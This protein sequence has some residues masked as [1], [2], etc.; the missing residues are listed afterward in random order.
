MTRKPTICGQLQAPAEEE[1]GER[2][3]QD[4]RE[5]PEERPLPHLFR[6]AARDAS[7]EPGRELEDEEDESR[8]RQRAEERPGR[9]RDPEGRRRP[10]RGRGRQAR[11]LALAGLADDLAG[12]EEADADRDA[13]DRAAQASAWPGPDRTARRRRAPSR[14][15][16][17]RASR[18]R[19]AC[20]RGAGSSRSRRR[21]ASPG[22]GAT[23]TI[24]SSGWGIEGRRAP[25]MPPRAD[26]GRKSI[27]SL[28]AGA[29]GAPLAQMNRGPVCAS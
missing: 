7:L 27:M 21:R 25:H 15:R 16:R 29:S 11:H 4:H 26:C 5:V 28:A 3:P 17:A 1:N 13:L 23:R 19:R 6:G 22:R 12:P 14:A 8:G 24:H 20:R 10:D 2:R 9:D 18:L